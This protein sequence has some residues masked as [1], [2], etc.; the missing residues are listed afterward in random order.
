MITKFVI[1]QRLRDAGYLIRNTN[2]RNLSYAFNP[3]AKMDGL[4]VIFLCDDSR[5]LYIS[6]TNIAYAVEAVMAD[7]QF[8]GNGQIS[9]NSIFVLLNDWKEK[10]LVMNNVVQISRRTGTLTCGKITP[11]MSEDFELVK[12][13]LAASNCL[14]R[15]QR[16]TLNMPQNQYAV[17]M[18]YILMAA[19]ILAFIIFGHNYKYY[20]FSSEHMS[21]FH[22]FSYMFMH[23]N[24]F[25]LVC[26][27]LSLYIAGKTLERSTGAMKTLCIYLIAG[28]Y[29]AVLSAFVHIGDPVV[30]VGASGAIYGLMGALLVEAAFTAKYGNTGNVRKC[31]Y[32]ILLSIISGFFAP[33]VDNAC[34]IGG[35]L[36]GVLFQAIFYLAD[37][38][39]WNMRT[40]QNN[41]IINDVLLKNQ[42][43]RM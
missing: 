20:G 14:E 18:T 4:H 30:T 15:A 7:P 24:L 43:N 16:G 39:E 40:I 23:G 13:I 5:H 37:N 38:I 19:N 11:E 41:R 25:H 33:N 26:N 21:V 8:P 34:H 3:V 9:W 31:F 27:M 28:V 36:G 22:V 17:R 10:A 29:G 32:I 42:K 6:D 12:S 1:E 2:I 35:F